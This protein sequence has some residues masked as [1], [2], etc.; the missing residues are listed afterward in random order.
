MAA[1]KPAPAEKKTAKKGDKFAGKKAPP[2]GSK[3]AK[4][5]K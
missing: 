1:K 2:F 4:E 5:K 3:D